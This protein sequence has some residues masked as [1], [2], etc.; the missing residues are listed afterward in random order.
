MEELKYDKSKLD[1][2]II[3]YL[4]SKDRPKDPRYFGTWKVEIETEYNPREFI[5]KYLKGDGRII[6]KN[7]KLVIETY[8]PLKELLELTLIE[9]PVLNFIRKLE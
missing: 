2:K 1:E 7:G 5:K 9:P 6:E 8:Y 3:K 4:E